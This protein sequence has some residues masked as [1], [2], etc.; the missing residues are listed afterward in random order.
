MPADVQEYFNIPQ[1]RELLQK[2][3]QMTPQVKAYK[4]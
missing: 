4:K 2:I 3:G 1:F